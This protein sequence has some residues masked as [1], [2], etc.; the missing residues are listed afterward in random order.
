MADFPHCDQNVLHTPGSCTYCDQF[1]GQQQC[2]LINRINFTGQDIKGLESCPSDAKRG[3]G[4]AH[5]WPGNVPRSKDCSC[6][7][8]Q[9]PDCWTHGGE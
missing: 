9:D 4:G 1:P 8:F 6:T 5:T 2:R 7:L 3:L